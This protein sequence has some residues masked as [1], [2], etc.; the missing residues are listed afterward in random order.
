MEPLLA[1][2]TGIVISL[3]A[4]FFWHDKKRMDIEE[5]LDFLNKYINVLVKDNDNLNSKIRDLEEKVFNQKETISK[6]KDCVNKLAFHTN[7]P[8]SKLVWFMD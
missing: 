5:R 3:L 8:K 2:V 4:G 1:I 6:L 7:F